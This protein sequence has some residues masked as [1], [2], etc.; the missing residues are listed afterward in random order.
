M[1]RQGL[2]TKDLLT[3]WTN[4]F[5]EVRPRG[6]IESGQIASTKGNLTYCARIKSYTILRPSWPGR[7][8]L[9][10][11]AFLQPAVLPLVPR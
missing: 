7:I 2:R 4:K 10:K 9:I 11:M 3:T 1:I 8:L 6:H 5:R